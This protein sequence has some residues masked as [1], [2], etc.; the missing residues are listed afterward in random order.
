MSDVRKNGID[1]PFLIFHFSFA[2][3]ESVALLCDEVNSQLFSET[4]TVTQ[5]DEENNYG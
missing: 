5:R 3:S 4:I 1:F 2:I